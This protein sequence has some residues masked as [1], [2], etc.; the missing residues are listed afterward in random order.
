[1]CP[2]CRAGPTRLV[3][4]GRLGEPRSRRPLTGAGP[5][6][7]SEFRK[8]RISSNPIRGSNAG[9]TKQ[10]PVSPDGMKSRAVGGA[11]SHHSRVNGGL[12]LET[13]RRL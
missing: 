13:V 2:S 8:C 11:Y 10:M 5:G 7:P 6:S 9:G 3:Q 12:G 4:A 1:M